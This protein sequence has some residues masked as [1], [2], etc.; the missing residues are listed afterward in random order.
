MIRFASDLSLNDNANEVYIGWLRETIVVELRKV[1]LIDGE[2]HVATR[3]RFE[4]VWPANLSPATVE[5]WRRR[6][7]AKLLCAVAEWGGGFVGR[8][9][10]SGSPLCVIIAGVV[11]YPQVVGCE[12]RDP[13]RFE[14]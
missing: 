4:K 12:C 8:F 10:R 7:G 5:I 1:A 14:L 13:I 3:V 6:D 11:A 2:F 9:E